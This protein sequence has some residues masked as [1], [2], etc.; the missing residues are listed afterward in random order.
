MLFTPFSFNV[1]RYLGES[2]VESVAS[3]GQSI[4]DKIN[5][6]AKA[7]EEQRKQTPLKLKESSPAQESKVKHATPRRTAK[8]ESPSS[9]TP[10]TDSV[11]RK[12]KKKKSAVQEESSDAVG[13]DND[14][15]DTLSP[16]VG[17]MITEDE[18]RDEDVTVAIRDAAML[19]A[20]ERK[21]RVIDQGLVPKDSVVTIKKK[22]GKRKYEQ[23]KVKEGE[24]VSETSKKATLEMKDE[25]MLDLSPDDTE[26]TKEKL[27]KKVGKR[28][29]T[30]RNQTT[31]DEELKMVSED[32]SGKEEE[33][34]EQM[35]VDKEEE[36]EGGGTVEEEKQESEDDKEPHN[37]V[38]LGDFERKHKKKKVMLS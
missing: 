2:P 36:E 19:T 16:Q 29:R 4:L 17:E 6:K 1:S 10:G 23:G 12:K 24:D 38:I 15:G 11:K 26:R 8:D 37:F 33:E 9:Q 5:A 34:E 13:Q 20:K 30:D 21:Q 22:K 31:E 27:K 28:D 7:R 3:P 35:E 32:E 25:E 18:K 14:G